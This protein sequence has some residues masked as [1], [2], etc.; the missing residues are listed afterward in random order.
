[1]VRAQAAPA[2][3][4]RER[5]LLGRSPRP[6]DTIGHH[7]VVKD[8]R[9]VSRRCTRTCSATTGPRHALQGRAG[10]RGVGAARRCCRA[11]PRL[12][13][14][15]TVPSPCRGASIPG[16]RP[17]SALGRNCGGVLALYRPDAPTDSHVRWVRFPWGVALVD[18]RPEH[19]T[20]ATTRSGAVA[21]GATPGQRRS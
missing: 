15:N 1:M 14:A 6:D 3:R 11:M 12:P 10:R 2:S 9:R 7:Q 17:V 19:S 20:G 16:R 5:H 4:C 8:R 13:G 18:R 21:S